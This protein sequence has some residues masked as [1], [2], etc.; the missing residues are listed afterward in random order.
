ML[1]QIAFT[2]WFKSSI[3]KLM[4]WGV[5]LYA[6]RH[7]QNVAAKYGNGTFE[8]VATGNSSHKKLKGI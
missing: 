5:I 4:G 6:L 2:L 8:I 7:K 3:E 1:P